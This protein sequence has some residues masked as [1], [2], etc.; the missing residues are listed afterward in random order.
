M[1]RELKNCGCTIQRSKLKQEVRLELNYNSVLDKPKSF[2]YAIPV[3]NIIEKGSIKL[4]WVCTNCN[5]E[6]E[7]LDSFEK[8]YLDGER[9][10]I[11]ILDDP[12]Q[13]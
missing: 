13:I 11:E 6:V 8:V 10:I 2:K 12:S 9:I 4:T 7:A 1:K 5:E 3:K